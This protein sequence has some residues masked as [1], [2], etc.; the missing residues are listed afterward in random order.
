MP[1]QDTS[2]L[3]EKIIQFIRTRGPSLPVHLSKEIDQSILFTSAFLSELL[4][5]KK[6]KISHMKVGC[7]PVYFIPGQESK[8]EKFSEHIKNKENEAY[9]LLR[10]EKFLKD[11]EQQP[12]IRV[13]LREI[14]DFAIPFKKD[15]EIIWRYLTTPESEFQKE[16]VPKQE[17][18][19]QIKEEPKPEIKEIPQ[20]QIPK[21]IIQEIRKQQEKEEIKQIEK[22]RIK[23]IEKSKEIHKKKPLKKIENSQKTNEKFFNKIKE[24]LSEKSIEIS[25]IQSFSKT[26]LRLKV[27]KNQKEYLLIAYNKKRI[28]EKDFIDAYKK[29]S[30]ID[31]P[32]IILSLGEPAKKMSQFIEAIKNLSGIE[33]VE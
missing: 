21:S 11:R 7:T 25:D 29:A 30:E 22:P 3:K 20:T 31:L 16:D 15:D 23:I 6:L 4:S 2:Q 17:E 33:K 13:A 12:A 27:V 8:L 26:D 28:V 14:K 1:A 24:Y 9:N 18:V 10:N 5:E 19:I 32:Y